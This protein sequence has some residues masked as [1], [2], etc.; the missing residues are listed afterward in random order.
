MTQ[1]TILHNGTTLKITSNWWWMQVVRGLQPRLPS[2]LI[3]NIRRSSALNTRAYFE[4][5][6]AGVCTEIF[7]GSK[8]ADITHWSTPLPGT[9]AALVPAMEITDVVRLEGDKE[10]RLQYLVDY[11]LEHTCI[12]NDYWHGRHAKQVIHPSHTG[13]GL[14]GGLI[15]DVETTDAGR[16]LILQTGGIL[17]YQGHHPIQPGI[18]YAVQRGAH[19]EVI[20][21]TDFHK[22]FAE[23]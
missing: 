8:H 6:R 12:K 17:H 10:M 7:F 11:L 15:S 2:E 20:R 19:V 14:W 23:V 9:G 4:N 5:R 18:D 3:L 1:A 21:P 13:S 22:Y 16:Q